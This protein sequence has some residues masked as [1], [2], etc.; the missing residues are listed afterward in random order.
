M[1]LN[2]SSQCIQLAVRQVNK[3]EKTQLRQREKFKFVRAH[4]GIELMTLRIHSECCSRKPP[5]LTTEYMLIYCIY[6]GYS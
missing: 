3:R 6:T 5:H 4:S 2:S 1:H